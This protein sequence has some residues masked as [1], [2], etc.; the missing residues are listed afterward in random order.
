M[1]MRNAEQLA[2]LWS[3]VNALLN[4]AHCC[5]PTSNHNACNARFALA[6]LV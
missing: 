1:V 6:A 3:Q 4:S 5:A 2:P